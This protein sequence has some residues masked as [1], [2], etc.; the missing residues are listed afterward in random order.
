MECFWRLIR[1][2]ASF[3]EKR[4]G[5]LVAFHMSCSLKSLKGGCIGEYL[6]DHYSGYCEGYQE[7]I[8]ELMSPCLGP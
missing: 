5:N 4:A 2:K 8:L 7:F 1:R 6:V 3:S